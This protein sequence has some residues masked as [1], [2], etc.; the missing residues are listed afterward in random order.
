MR[1]SRQIM[2]VGLLGTVLALCFAL[3]R[4]SRQPDAP[5]PRVK[6][7]VASSA[8]RFE[9]IS[10]EGQFV[11][12]PDQ[13]VTL[14]DGQSSRAT[15]VLVKAGDSVVKGQVLAVMSTTRP[16]RLPGNGNVQSEA[17]FAQRLSDDLGA[18][19]NNHEANLAQAQSALESAQREHAIA[20]ERAQSIRDRALNATDSDQLRETKEALDQARSVRDKAQKLADRD[21]R[22]LQEGWISRNQATAS[23]AAYDQAETVFRS[24]QD[25]YDDAR[26]GPSD[27]EAKSAREAYNQAK[28]EADSKLHEAEQKVIAAHSGGLAFNKSTPI[29]LPKLSASLLGRINGQATIRSPFDGVVST[30]SPA[31]SPFQIQLM[32]RDAK[33][34]LTASL[35][36]GSAARLKP[37]MIAE[38]PSG[39]SAQI[40]SIGVS[41]QK[42]SLVPMKLATTVSTPKPGLVQLVVKFQTSSQL[43]SIP[44]SALVEWNGEQYVC[45]IVNGQIQHVPV[46]V[47]SVEPFEKLLIE[48][49]KSGAIVVTSGP[50]ALKPGQRVVSE[51]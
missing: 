45:T 44:A 39:Q 35:E 43:L 37:G 28:S 23:K 15:R 25:R 38:L 27:R 42:T 1:A 2:T 14:G 11:V 29:A 17:A 13:S 41:D 26:R 5:L 8:E 4:G 24:A 36:P 40:T 34:Q 19:L 12:P 46:T 32:K 18:A 30:I 51:K 47:R 6:T 9:T 48:G 21:A 16:S 20:L 31:G 10:F 50:E 49:L 7:S 3:P 33:V 22:A